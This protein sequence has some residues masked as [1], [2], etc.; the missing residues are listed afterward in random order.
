MHFIS[1]V[2]NKLAFQL[3]LGTAVTNALVLYKE[4]THEQIQISEF[5]LELIKE[6][7]DN[8]IQSSPLSSSKKHKLVCETETTNNRNKRRRCNKCYVNL[9]KEFGRV[10]AQKKMQTSKHILCYL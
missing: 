6:L 3:L 9:S 1:E 8:P 2:R 10:H 5:R 7:L 4:T